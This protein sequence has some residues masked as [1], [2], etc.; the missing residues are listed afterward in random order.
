M[1]KAKEIGPCDLSLQRK[2]AMKEA[3]V[4]MKQF[5]AVG[6]PVDGK[7]FGE[8]LRDSWD[9]IKEQAMKCPI[10]PSLPEA[11]KKL[12]AATAK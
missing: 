8:I 10:G 4:E 3:N 11:R 6:I 2:L 7:L 1:V 9:R 12:K 5:Q